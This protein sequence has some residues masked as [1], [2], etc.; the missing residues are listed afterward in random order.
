MDE[1]LLGLMKKIAR[2]IIPDNGSHRGSSMFLGVPGHC[3]QKGDGGTS[4][5]GRASMDATILYKELDT[6]GEG[7]VGPQNM[8]EPLWLPLSCTKSL[9]QMG[10][11]W[12]D[13]K[14]WKSLYGCHYP[15]QRA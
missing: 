15:V 1:N 5:L 4:K 11:E 10:R 2:F 13:L 14:T 3:L 8:E 6:D 7:M 9:T 12:W